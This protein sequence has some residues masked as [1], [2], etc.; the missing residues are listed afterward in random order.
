MIKNDEEENIILK[1]DQES[2]SFSINRN[3]INKNNQIKST[4]KKKDNSIYYFWIFILCFSL[5]YFIIDMIINRNPSEIKKKI[6]DNNN[7]NIID[8]NKAESNNENNI[9]AKKYRRNIDEKIGVAFVFISI[10]G[11][12]IGRMLS[13]LSNELIKMD[14]KY[15]IYLITQSAENLDFYIDKRVIRLPIYGNYTLI[16]EF[17]KSSNVIYYVLHNVLSLRVINFYKSFN[18]K[19]INIEHGAYLASVYTNITGVYKEWQNNFLFDAFVQVVPDDYYV[20]KKLGMNNTF[21]IPNLYTFNAAETPNSNLTYKN[22]MVMGRE[23]DRV[24]GGIYSIKAMSLIVK[25]I[26]NA[27]MYFITSDPRI[28]FIEDLINELN[29]TKNIEIINYA[30]NVSK[31]FLNSSVLLYPSLSESFPMVMNEGKAHAVP[32]V[33]FNVSY[34]PSYQKGV[35]LVDMLNV[36]QMAEETIKLLN[37]YDYRKNKG[38]EGKKSLN[39][40]SNSE[41]I[42]KWDRLFSIL[43]KDDSIAYEQI[44]EY[45]YEN[46][47]DEE[48]AKERLESN[49]NFG[50][51]YNKYFECHSF[52]DMINLSYINHIE[53]CENMKNKN[54][55]K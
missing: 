44:Q 54:D 9:F 10:Y 24:K 50:I 43:N 47:Y 39:D 15:D 13:L 20:Y 4:P 5:L 11:N 40:Y 14:D 36:E 46:Y 1:K 52:N 21:F 34:S 30:T 25:E 45:T 7:K 17:D 6:T 23:N 19:V 26:P 8:Y 33:A 31:Y 16:E 42:N 32:I 22:I 41:T 12:G 51:K 3:N 27:K 18:K 38:M 37:S 29:L 55:K 53:G 49:Y 28:E 2:E 35:I 48:K